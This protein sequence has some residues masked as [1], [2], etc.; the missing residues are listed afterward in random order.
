[1]ITKSFYRTAGRFCKCFTKTKVQLQRPSRKLK[2]HF[3]TFINK[4]DNNNDNQQNVANNNNSS[5]INDNKNYNKEIDK[6]N[7]TINDKQHISDFEKSNIY[8][9]LKDKIHE[10]IEQEKI[11]LFMKGT[12]ENPLCG[13]SA[14]VVNILSRMNLKEYIYI[15]VLKN[16]NLREAIKIYSNWPYIPILYVNKEFIGGHDIISDL[17][18]SGELTD[19]MK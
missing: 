15:D 12:P 9:N 1:M 13:Y 19:I 3:T 7:I 6:D 8:K 17:Y 16:P 18:N 10:I 2:L 11:V 4:N 14:N 5:N